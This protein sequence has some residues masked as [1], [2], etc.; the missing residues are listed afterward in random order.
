[1]Q[2]HKITATLN[3]DGINYV[4]DLLFGD[5]SDTYPGEDI[6]THDERSAARL[7]L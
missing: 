3:I 4:T 5:W 2:R 7:R 1:M 6:L